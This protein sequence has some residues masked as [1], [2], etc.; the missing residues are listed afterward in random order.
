MTAT[1]RSRPASSARRASDHTG[2]ELT[3]NTRFCRS[4]ALFEVREFGQGGP[5]VICS[6]LRHYPGEHRVM[7]SQLAQA[8]YVRLDPGSHFLEKG[9]H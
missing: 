6:S 4:G 1:L 7:G 2:T 9:G 3:S 5:E 8:R